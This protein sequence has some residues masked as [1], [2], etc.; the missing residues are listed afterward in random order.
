[1]SFDDEICAAPDAV[2]AEQA[3][4]RAAPPALVEGRDDAAAPLRSPQA[5]EAYCSTV[6]ERLSRHAARRV[7][8]LRA[9]HERLQALLDA[10][11]EVGDSA[12]SV[13]IRRHT[14]AARELLDAAERSGGPA[15]RARSAEEPSLWPDVAPPAKPVPL[16]H[17]ASSRRTLPPTRTAAVRSGL[18]DAAHHESRYGG[19][20]HVGDGAG[21][22]APST[23]RRPVRPLLDIER[24]A[25]LL[26]QDVQGWNDR[27][28]LQSED[29][30]LNAVSC[31][32][33]RSITCRYRRLREEAGDTE[34]AEVTELAEDVRRLM[35]DAG[36]TE[37]T[38][39]LDEELVPSPTAFQWG[40]VA[41][42]Y[43]ELAD[44]QF[45]YEWWDRHRAEIGVAD[46]A[47]LA[48][49]IAAIQQRFNRLLF[50]VGA[51][52][53]FQQRLFDTLRTWA[54]EA[55]CYL[56][57]LRPKAPLSE[58]AQRAATLESAWQRAI[59]AVN[60]ASNDAVSTVPAED[61]PAEAG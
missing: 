48:E 58:L 19:A 43:Q 2:S 9:A 15:S 50:R 37:Y 35:S 12:L 39:A 30:G 16:D 31:L 40:E 55:P 42:R 51:R 59:S 38:L 60:V 52:D 46:V 56:Y 17:P 25:A 28:P 32:R 47:P 8:F 53:P 24:D 18:P 54:R 22:Q 23:P 33:L 34:V 36:D 61:I 5:L 7:A 44:A 4:V 10:A 13:E 27:S 11:T 29:G 14:A 45:V 20:G 6:H 49:A 41:E 1:M 57:S 21:P 26:R 3:V